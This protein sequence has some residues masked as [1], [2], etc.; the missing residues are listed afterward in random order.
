M[1]DRF[2]NIK[3]TPN[4]PFSKF[5]GT[6]GGINFSANFDLFL[7]R[8]AWNGGCNFED[9][10]DGFGRGWIGTFGDWLAIRDSSDEAKTKMFQRSLNFFFGKN[11]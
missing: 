1:K 11:S 6:D 3:I 2:T 5:T 9:I 4:G 8:E 7:I 10:A